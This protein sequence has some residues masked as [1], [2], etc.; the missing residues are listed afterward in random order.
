[1]RLRFHHS[2]RRRR[3]EET[4]TFFNW[5][6]KFEEHFS[7]EANKIRLFLRLRQICRL[8]SSEE[9]KGFKCR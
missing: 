6:A 5:F 9:T 2:R 4:P 1:M 3:L 7:E 8:N